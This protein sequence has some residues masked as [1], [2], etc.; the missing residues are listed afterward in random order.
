MP[1][2]YPT[3]AVPSASGAEALGGETHERTQ[4]P[5][6]AD[7]VSP[8]S[9]PSFA[10]QDNR[11]HWLIREIL[12]GIAE[13]WLFRTTTL[14]VGAFPF[15]YRKADGTAVR[16]EGGTLAVTASQ[17]NYLY[18]LH[19]TNALT[20]D[21]TS[22][23]AD[24]TTFTALGEAVCD[25]SDITSIANRRGLNLYQTN[26]SS[27]SPTGTTA[28]TFTT[29]NDN[30]GA[31][32]DGGYKHNRGTSGEGACARRGRGRHAGGNRCVGVS[33]RGHEGH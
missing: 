27:S 28:S 32:A 21:T 2:T 9:S 29:D 6:L 1:D 7:G 11:I 30:A 13:G 15:D 17:T 23:P 20:K 24:I 33:G 31:G 26:A 19:S 4:V 25:G 22:F 5:F 18:I 12:A 14:Q 10:V 3:P 8:D 16:F